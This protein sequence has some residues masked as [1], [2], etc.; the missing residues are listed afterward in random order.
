MLAQVGTRRV[1]AE[2]LRDS[3]WAAVLGPAGCRCPPRSRFA[4]SPPGSPWGKA[5]GEGCASPEPPAVPVGCP[6]LTCWTAARLWSWALVRCCC[7]SAA[8]CSMRC[9]C[10]AAYICCRYCAAVLGCRCSAC[11]ITFGGETWPRA[12]P[13]PPWCPPNPSVPPSPIPARS[14]GRG[15]RCRRRSGA[16][17]GAWPRCWR[18]LGPCH[19]RCWREPEPG[20]AH[21]PWWGRGGVEKVGPTRAGGEWQSEHLV[22]DEEQGAGITEEQGGMEEERWETVWFIFLHHSEIGERER[23]QE[24]KQNRR[25]DGQAERW[26]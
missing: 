11:W 16:R 12:V 21:S 14:G 20:A 24:D 7:W 15:C 3:P 8:V 4:G 9:C 26:R 17:A 25:K 13:R 6:Y 5:D 2:R 23:A 19:R 10:C 22:L 1:G 18:A